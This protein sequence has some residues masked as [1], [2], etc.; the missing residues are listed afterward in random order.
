M[1]W[2]S[3]ADPVVAARL[4]LPDGAE[5]TKVDFFGIDN[6]GGLLSF[7]FTSY[8]PDGGF[9]QSHATANS[10][11]ASA[12]IRTFTATP[13]SP[14]TIVNDQR[15]YGLSAT[16]SSPGPNMLFSGARVFFTPP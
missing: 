14:V 10:T 13:T 1:E 3:G 8:S 7:G 9:S 15:A 5:V 4:D 12:A 6:T 16:T 2:V 11:A